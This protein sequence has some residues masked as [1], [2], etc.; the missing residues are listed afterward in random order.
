MDERPQPYGR[1]QMRSSDLGLYRW[2]LADGRRWGRPDL[3]ILV[4]LFLNLSVG[5]SILY[6]QELDKPA[7]NVPMYDLSPPVP[8]RG[9]GD[10]G[11]PRIRI[12]AT[13]RQYILFLHSDL[14][15]SQPPYEVNLLDKRRKTLWSEQGQ[16]DP[17]GTFSLSLPAKFLDPG[18][19][20]IEVHGVRG[21]G[22]EGERVLVATYPLDFGYR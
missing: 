10:S 3:R 21:Q 15:T 4:A 8:V 20:E 14:G 2:A 22:P 7:A 18:Q 19:Y 11:P 16:P 1:V 12:P 5:L 6:V 13:A 17:S 9:D